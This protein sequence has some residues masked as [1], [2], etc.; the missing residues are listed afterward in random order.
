MG[1]SVTGPG[2]SRLGVGCGCESMVVL[3]VDCCF[4]S[5]FVV[6]FSVGWGGSDCV[7]VFNVG[8][9]FEYATLVF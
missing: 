3:C 8:C 9:G 1:L 5:V 7:V 6:E 4:E 2:C